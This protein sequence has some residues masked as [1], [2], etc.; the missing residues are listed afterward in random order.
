MPNRIIKE[1]ICTSDTIDGLSWF[2]EV[3]FYRLIVSCDDFGRFDGRP[4]II[5]NKLFPL[6]EN[7]TVK[8][9]SDAICK[10]STVGLVILYSYEDKL[11]RY[12]ATVDDSLMR[13]ILTL[14]FVEGM[15]WR[16]VARSIGGGNTEDSVKQACSRFLR[17]DETCHECHD[18]M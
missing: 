17:K 1:S 14:R 4:I 16:K 10:L 15:S 11:S 18:P 2:E 5:K 9:V 13:Q 8:S 6:K 7:I 12:I 3:L